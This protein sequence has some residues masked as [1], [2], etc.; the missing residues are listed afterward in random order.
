[1]AVTKSQIEHLQDV[2]QRLIPMRDPYLKIWKKVAKWIDPWYGNMDM[3]TTPTSNDLPTS[4]EI[5][6][7]TV[8]Y[9]SQVFASGLQ[10]YTCS[11][12]SAFF[13]LAPEDPQDAK[14]N[15][16]LAETLQA[17][18]RSMYRVFSSSKLY[19]SLH[20]LLKSFGD[21]GTAIMIMGR[22]PDTLKPY[23]NYVPNYQCLTI[24]DNFHGDVD[25]LFRT[26]WLTA[27]D[28]KKQFGEDN[29]PS[30]VLKCNDKMQQFKFIQVFAPRGRFDL[31]VEADT[32]FIEVVW[33]AEDTKKAVFEGGTKF[34]RFICAP[35]AE[36]FDGTAWG[37]GAPG[38]RQFSSSHSMQLMMKDQMNASRFMAAPPLKKTENLIAD[39]KPGGFVNI[40]PGGDIAPL[41]MGADVSWNNMTRQ[42]LRAQA[43]A[44]YFVDFFLM[45]SQY[46]GQVNTAT[47]AQGLQNEQIKMMT[48][49]L[50]V[51][52]T[53]LFEP[54]IEWTW[55]AMGEEGLFKDGYS[56]SYDDLNVDYISPLYRIQ[57]QAV[58]LEPTVNAMN[59]ITPYLEL[60]KSLM[61]YINLPE[62]A[63]IVRD[64]TGADVRVMRSD[65]EAEKILNAQAQAAK[66]AEED[67][68]DIEKQ[69]AAAAAYS[70][71]AKA[72][73]GGSP[74][75]RQMDDRYKNLTF[76]GM[77]G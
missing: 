36:S 62:Y 32:E 41:Q 69:K 75:Q 5:Y 42:D 39:I 77:N 2:Y 67:T 28:A 20:P 72:P 3:S 43:K 59:L 61:A 26:I 48:Y 74:A 71:E 34:R 29:L 50:D 65:E 70:A 8:G 18:T 40:P 52:S 68:M 12:Q 46:S 1:M 6:D 33:C 60:D 38:M 15:T 57:R 7:S 55:N 4:S 49:F 13:E 19:R 10:G 47:L 27:Y 25:T 35:W 16:N 23:F 21:L 17:R 56:I 24:K 54:L 76:G 66:Q 51:L 64:G 37:V 14:K 11:S 30:T 73:E 22:H 63:K 45:L 58:S 31:D 53:S 9:Y 44:D